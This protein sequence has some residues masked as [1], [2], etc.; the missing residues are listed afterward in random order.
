MAKSQ[1]KPQSKPSQNFA[2]TDDLIDFAVVRENVTALVDEH[3]D[4]NSSKCRLALLTLLKEVVAE[5]HAI[6]EQKLLEDGSGL[7]CAT[8]LSNLQDELIGVIHEFALTYI[9]RVDNPS[10]GERMAVIAVG[11]YGRGT[12]AP[13]SDIDLLFLLP[14]KQTPW[15]ESV[16]EYILYMLWDM[17]FK[18]GHATRDVDECVRLSKQDFTIRTAIL[19][20]RFL[21]GDSELFDDLETRFDKEVI[22]G[23]GA[24]FIEA[25]MEERDE[26]HRKAGNTRYLVEPNVKE[27]KGGLRDLHTLFWISKYF[28]RLKTAHEL[29]KAGIFTRTEYQTFQR[30]GDFLWAVR[31]HMHYL[32]G[33][34][35]ERLSFDLQREMAQ[36]LNYQ[37]KAGMLDVER[38]MKHYFLVAKDVGNLTNILSTKLEQEQVKSTPG[39]SRLVAAVRGRRP[40]AI[41]GNKEFLLENKRIIHANLDVFKEDPI[42]LLRVFQIADKTGHSLHPNLL[43]LMSK[44]LKLIDKN[45]RNSKE[46]NK[47]FLTIVASKRDPET[48]LRKMNE[49]GVL[50]RFIPDFGKIIAMMQFNMYH[51]YTVDEHTIRAVGM[52]ALIERG[53]LAEEHPLANDVIDTI[54]DRL[55]LY[56]TLFLH[57]I[58]KGRPEDHSIAGAK[59]AKK[60]GKRMGLTSSQIDTVSW[61][62]L[63]HLTMSVI[64]QSRDLSD[65]KT[66]RDF[67]NIVQTPERLKLLLILT[68]C[69]IRAVG[70]G[71]WNGWK[72]QLLR[73][74]YYETQPLLTGGFNVMA[75]EE[76]ANI[77]R[78]ELSTAL[79][80]WSKTDR[81]S[82]VERHYP[83]YLLRTDIE[84]QVRHANFI[85]TSHKGEVPLSTDVRT[86]AFEGI[87]EITIY[88]PDQPNI[89]SILA[90]ACS[91]AGASIVGAQIFTTR[92]GFALDMINIRREFETEEDEFRRAKRIGE[93]IELAVA[94]QIP[95]QSGGKSLRSIKRSTKA[96]TV[97][98][99]IVVDNTLSNN[100]TVIEASGKD[101]TGLLRDLANSLYELNLNTSTAHISTFGERAVDVFYVT[102]LLGQKVADKTRQ[103][104]I[105]RALEKVFT[106][107]KKPTKKVA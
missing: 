18:V 28:Y 56:V 3:G 51:H 29:L 67:A 98:T 21:W 35:E 33:R 89:L 48:I 31:C 94:G 26:R 80:D 9:Y 97:E 66:I 65:P 13:G 37:T 39:I 77:A 50:G 52:L 92:D 106:P 55:I 46:A 32:T 15:G 74:L 54:D 75:L 73:T 40:S 105:K 93:E 16:V 10:S 58:A 36:R 49:S 34:A 11:G 20:A 78:E 91:R 87:T 7:K 30:S 27:G 19:E 23:S 72:G 82:Y 88:A 85:L 5:G 104:R 64:A 83:P 103:N 100:F 24:Q 8:R 45:V 53:E 70:P 101:R 47:L 61:L 17:N 2:E 41:K 6:A 99:T 84:T 42:N 96:F 102:D 62:V 90:G 95:E 4:P 63:E 14:Y 68:V 107:P 69:D 86:S 44:S 22:Q 25:K 43:H 79:L 81:D 1:A 12:L 76:R 59:V 57:D 60:L 38:F 71:V